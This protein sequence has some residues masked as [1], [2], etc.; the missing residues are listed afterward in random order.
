MAGSSSK[1][2]RFALLSSLLAATLTP[3]AAAAGQRS[4]PRMVVVDERDTVRDEPP[5]HGAIGMSTAYRISEGIEGRQME[6]SKRVLPPCT[7][8]GTHRLAPAADQYVPAGPGQVSYRGER[9]AF[10]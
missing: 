3:Y 10:N 6:F 1:K 8:I 4:A 5:P 7:A 9:R 2:R